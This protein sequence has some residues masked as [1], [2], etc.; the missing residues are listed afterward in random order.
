MNKIGK[1]QKS[2][3]VREDNGLTYYIMDS[4]ACFISS[5]QGGVEPRSKL[6]C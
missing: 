5:S 4:T 1:L 3:K 2:V 6:I